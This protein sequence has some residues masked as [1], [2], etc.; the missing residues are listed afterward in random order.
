MPQQL[1]ASNVSQQ[2]DNS[3]QN[4]NGPDVSEEPIDQNTINSYIVS[5]DLPKKN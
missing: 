3:S 1:G 5:P 4:Q 2:N